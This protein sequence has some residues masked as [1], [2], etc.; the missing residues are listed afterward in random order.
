MLTYL[1]FPYQNIIKT[2]LDT[3]DENKQVQYG[4]AF[5]KIEK[6]YPSLKQ[7]YVFE[8]LECNYPLVFYK[9]ILNERKQFNIQNIELDSLRNLNAK[10]IILDNQIVKISNSNIPYKIIFKANNCWLI[11]TNNY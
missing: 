7:F 2:I 9:K 8:P 4:Y 1:Y 5:K 6:E 3:N 11:E 10:V